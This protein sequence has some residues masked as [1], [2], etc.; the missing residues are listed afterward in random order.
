MLNHRIV[1]TS[2]DA[3]LFTRCRFFHLFLA[4]GFVSSHDLYIIFLFEF[5]RSSLF[6]H[7]NKT[8]IEFTKWV[9]ALLLS[10]AIPRIESDARDNVIVAHI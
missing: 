5:V 6:T 4:V 10:Y 8:K 7:T 1:P 9:Q 3:I 2:G